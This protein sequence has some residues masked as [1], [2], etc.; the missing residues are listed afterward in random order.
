M[1]YLWRRLTARC[2]SCG[3]KLTL[4]Q[5][6]TE[7]IVQINKRSTKLAKSLGRWPQVQSCR[8]C[9]K[10]VFEGEPGFV[11]SFLLIHMDYPG[12]MLPKPVRTQMMNTAS[13]GQS[14][15]FVSESA[16][17]QPS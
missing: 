7:R 17:K 14:P 1:K 16:N 5:T 6:E 11:Q 13:T 15:S 10:I 2:M 3:Q 4:G 8:K 9:H 12:P